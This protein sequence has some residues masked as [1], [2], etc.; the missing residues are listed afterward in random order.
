ECL[1]GRNVLLAREQQGHIYRYAGEGRLLDRRKTLLGT[2]D[3]DKEVWALR[4]GMQILRGGDGAF[5]IVRQQRRHFEGDP[6][7]DAVRLAV[8]RPKEVGGAAEVIERQLEKQL[9]PRLTFLELLADRAVVG[10]TVLDRVVENRRVGGQPGHR[11]LVD[12]AFERAARQ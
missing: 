3:L 1:C 4:S 9:L 8:D 7:V 12:V 2:R 5:G 11:Q 10:S 6:T